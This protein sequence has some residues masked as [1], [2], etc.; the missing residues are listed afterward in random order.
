[1]TSERGSALQPMRICIREE[2]YERK[3]GRIRAEGSKLRD[4]S[5]MNQGRYPSG[6][7]RV[8]GSKRRNPIG[9]IRAEGS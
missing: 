5:G 9:C 6:G 8:E 4:P 2:G 1:M 7:I 3:G